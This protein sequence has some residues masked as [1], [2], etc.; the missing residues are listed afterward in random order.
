M[1]TEDHEKAAEVGDQPPHRG[2]VTTLFIK[3]PIMTSLVMV[4]ILFFGI[5]AYRQLAGERSAERRLPDDHRH[6]GAARREPGDDGGDGGDA[7]REAVLDHRG[8]RQHDVDVE[9]GADADRRAVLARPEHRCGR[10]G[11]AVGDHANAAAAAAGDSAALVPEDESGGRT[12][13]DTRAHEHGGADLAAG[14]VRRDHDR[15]ASLDGGRRGAGARVRR[16]EI[17]RAHPARSQAARDAQSGAR[18]HHDGGVEPER[19]SADGRAV[20]P[21]GRAHG[22]GDRAARER[23][24]SSATWSSP[25]ATARPCISRTWAA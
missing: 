20:G 9:P 15:A 8:H 19:Q 5:V 3:R 7:A 13:P 21:E 2:G 4:A 24:C 11:C 23:G 12:D 1:A 6:G 18:G 17:R 16:A 22:A 14:R 10:A 25:I